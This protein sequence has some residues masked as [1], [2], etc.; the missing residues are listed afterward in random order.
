VSRPIAGLCG[1]RTDSSQRRE[2]ESSPRPHGA[3]ALNLATPAPPSSF[4][5]VVPVHPGT[6][7]GPSGPG[8]AGAGGVRTRRP[9]PLRSQTSQWCGRGGSGHPGAGSGRRH[10]GCGH[11]G[12]GVK[13]KRC[14][15]GDGVTT[16]LGSSKAQ[17]P[18]A[19]SPREILSPRRGLCRGPFIGHT[20]KP[21]PRA[22][23]KTSAK[24]NPRQNVNKKKP[25]KNS[26]IILF[27]WRRRTSHALSHL[28]PLT[29][30]TLYHLCLYSILIPHIF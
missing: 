6:C 21:L 24:K 8:D 20:T 10:D 25:E 27:F 18:S 29:T 26:K 11:P 13:V 1:C 19:K 3:T 2:R 23:K 28:P 4:R 14:S 16:G 7:G 30:P 12:A 22:K 17:K 5:R 9:R 15:P